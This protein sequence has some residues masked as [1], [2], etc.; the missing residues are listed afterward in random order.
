MDKKIIRIINAILLIII[1]ARFTIF[2]VNINHKCTH[3]SDCEICQLCKDFRKNIDE[4]N[5]FFISLVLL[6]TYLVSNSNVSIKVNC[7]EIYSQTLISLKI[8]LSN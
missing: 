1:L 4:Y 5:P 7:F 8:K 6:M 3:D 2:N